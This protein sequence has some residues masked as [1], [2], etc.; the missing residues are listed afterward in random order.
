[1]DVT[2]T[3]GKVRVVN[4]FRRDVQHDFELPGNCEWCSKSIGGEH[5]HVGSILNRPLVERA[6]AHEQIVPTVRWRW[7]C[8]II[9][10]GGG[11]RRRGKGERWLGHSLCRFGR[12]ESAVLLQIPRSHCVFWPILH[13]SPV[14]TIGCVVWCGHDVKSEMLHM[15][16]YLGRCSC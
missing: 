4:I 12:F 5:D 6:A 2:Q 15:L 7:I 9:G 16:R 1:M 8:W 3:N 14:V 10:V 13:C 11:R